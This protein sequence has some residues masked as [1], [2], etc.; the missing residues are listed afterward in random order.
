VIYLE[1]YTPK[2]ILILGL[3]A[4]IASYILLNAIFSTLKDKPTIVFGEQI[5]SENGNELIKFI[6]NIANKVGAKAPDNIIIGLEPNFYVTAASVALAGEN[7]AL[8]GTTMYLSLPFLRILS[9]EELTGVIGHELGHFKGEDT[10]YTMR[11]YP[12]YKRLYTAIGGLIQHTHQDSGANIFGIP[13]IRILSFVLNEFSI[14]ERTIGRKREFEAD[15]VGSAVSS[16]IALITALLKVS[17]YAGIWSEL[18][19]FNVEKLDEG[20]LLS[21]LSY[22][23]CDVSKNKFSNL[24]FE[25]TIVN[26]LDYKMAHLTDTHPTLNERMKALKID[27]SELKKDFLKPEDFDLTQYFYE[28]D[29]ITEGLSIK[30]HRLMITL[31]YA[32]LPENQ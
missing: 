32:T 24:D 17:E 18:R 15:K 2:L 21:D 9:K 19:K 5:T 6:A 11:F 22:I 1:R 31:G 4:I 3:G 13:A 7:Q 27:I 29:K 20:V 23:Y 28:P 8:S 12:S 26:L 14:T 30:E 10:V 25:H 16:G